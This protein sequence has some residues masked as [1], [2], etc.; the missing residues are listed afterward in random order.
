[1]YY[2]LAKIYGGILIDYSQIKKNKFS[3]KEDGKNIKFRIPKIKHNNEYKKIIKN[4]IYKK[5]L[6]MKKVKILTG[7]IFL[8]MAPL[9]AYP[10]DKI[11]FNYSR[12]ILHEEIGN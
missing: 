8:N 1:M 6:D 4:Y 5:K 3:F 7:I 11:L 12:K 10:F 2:D 9:H